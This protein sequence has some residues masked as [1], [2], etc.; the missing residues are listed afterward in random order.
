MRRK[1]SLSRARRSAGLSAEQLADDPLRIASRRA[2]GRQPAPRRERVARAPA[3][4]AD[5]RAAP[6]LCRRMRADR[7]ACGRRSR[8]RDRSGRG[9]VPAST[10]DRRS[11]GRCG[12]RDRLTT[13]TSRRC[14]GRCCPVAPSLRWKRIPEG[15]HRD[16]FPHQGLDRRRRVARAARR[17]GTAVLSLRPDQVGRIPSPVGQRR[18]SLHGG[19][20]ASRL[21][22]RAALPGSGGDGAV[23]RVCRSGALVAGPRRSR[24]ATRRA[25]GS[26]A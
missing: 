10:A 19:V 2:L 18:V 26:S 22:T 24:H 1:Q 9:R 12:G 21:R 14:C 7:P 11:P 13:A 8:A 20:Q 23:V 3:S 4:I 15:D 25:S 16:R 6:A 17:A 5:R